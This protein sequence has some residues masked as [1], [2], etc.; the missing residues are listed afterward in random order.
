MNSN[1]F[2]RL[3]TGGSFLENVYNQEELEKQAKKQAIS[4]VK[5]LGGLAHQQISQAIGESGVEA[6]VGAA[7]IAYP[8]VKKYGGQVT[9]DF[10]SMDLG[11]LSDVKDKIVNSVTDHVRGLRQGAAQ[12][13]ATS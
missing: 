3:N 12:V 4:Q 2:D 6:A 8:L 13:Q 11:G 5:A 10:P 7:G 9:K 1:L